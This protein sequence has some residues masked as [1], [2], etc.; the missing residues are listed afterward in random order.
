MAETPAPVPPVVHAVWKPDSA[1]LERVY[2]LLEK[3]GLSRAVGTIKS[4]LAP[5]G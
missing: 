2:E 1:T 5:K 4:E 3:H